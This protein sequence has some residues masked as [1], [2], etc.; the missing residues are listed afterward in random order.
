ME[1]TYARCSEKLIVYHQRC[2]KPRQQSRNRRRLRR[3]P[4]QNEASDNGTGGCRS[5]GYIGVDVGQSLALLFGVKFSKALEGGI[6]LAIAL[7]GIGAIIGM[8]NGAFST[9]L[10]KF[11]TNTEASCH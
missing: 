9:S 3:R 11:V 5:I 8:L 2:K 10:E 6:K 4:R 7:T 1:N